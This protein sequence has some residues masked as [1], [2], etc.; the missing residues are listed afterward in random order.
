MS[1]WLAYV[2]LE[3]LTSAKQDYLMAGQVCATVANFSTWKMKTP[4]SPEDVFPL[5]KQEVIAK[6][7]KKA[8]K[9]A[10]EKLDKE[11]QSALLM[12]ALF[13]TSKAKA[14]GPKEA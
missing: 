3:G 7:V 2:D 9:K 11:A 14:Y 12:A 1:E 6:P 10:A 4:M 13:K 8:K 5:L